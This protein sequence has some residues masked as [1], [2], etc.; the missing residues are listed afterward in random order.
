M[1]LTKYLSLFVFAFLL[2]C[3]ADKSE[4]KHI[5]TTLDPKMEK[6]KGVEIVYSEK[7]IVQVVIKAEVVYRYSDKK[8]PYTEMPS[9]LNI[10]FYNDLGVAVNF[11]EAEYGKNEESKEIMHARGN[12]KLSNL[13]GE[14]LY[15]EELYWN[16]KSKKVYSEKFVKIETPDEIIYGE[17]FESDE[18]FS[19]YVIKKIKGSVSTNKFK[20]KEVKKK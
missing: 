9:G 20:N 17:G 1:L 14:H 6:G 13:D 12:V 7:G 19:N 18:D 16:Q 15:A 4:L 5:E 11:L 3:S 8:S 2:S 10:I